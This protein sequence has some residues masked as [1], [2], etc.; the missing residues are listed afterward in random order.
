M[1]D[2]GKWALLLFPE[3]AI[4]TCEQIGLTAQKAGEALELNISWTNHGPFLVGVMY[5]V[6]GPLIMSH[7]GENILGLKF[8]CAK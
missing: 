6:D 7:C 2:W 8:Q 5:L 4:M 3:T 1:S